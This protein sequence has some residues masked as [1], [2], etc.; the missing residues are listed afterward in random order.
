[1]QDLLDL[2]ASNYDISTFTRVVITYLL[3]AKSIKLVV[4][5]KP[6]QSP[7]RGSHYY[8]WDRKQLIR[9]VMSGLTN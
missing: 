4:V 3:C 9:G 1:M 5:Q 6:S 7:I 8:Y 2:T